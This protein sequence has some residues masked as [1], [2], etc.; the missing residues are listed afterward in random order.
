MAEV[1]FD[2]AFGASEVE[3]ILHADAGDA[4]GAF[5]GT[6][7]R[8]PLADVEMRL[9]GF[10]LIAP[11]AAFLGVDAI[12]RQTADFRIRGN[13]RVNLCVEERE[14]GGRRRGEEEGEKNG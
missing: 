4:G 13:V 1:A 11:A 12:D 14:R 9:E 2:E 5:G 3:M 6:L 10:E 7:D 8:I